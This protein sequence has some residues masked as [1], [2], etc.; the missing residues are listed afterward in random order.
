LI[1]T[2]S[3][4]I[5]GESTESAARSGS[6]AIRPDVWSRPITPGRGLRPTSGTP[7]VLVEQRGHFDGE[8]Q[9]LQHHTVTN[10]LGDGQTSTS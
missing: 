7:Q 4:G 1:E 5:P 2:F 10:T 9:H 8:F 3:S 6:W